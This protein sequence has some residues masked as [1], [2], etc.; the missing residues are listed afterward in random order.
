MTVTPSYEF[1][2]RKAMQKFQQIDE[3]EIQINQDGE[4][5]FVKW[6]K[7]NIHKPM[8]DIRRVMSLAANASNKGNF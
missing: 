6:C 8:K 7:Q 3:E 1:L 2:F 5:A 4:R